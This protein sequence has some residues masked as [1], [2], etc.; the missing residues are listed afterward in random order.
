MRI[1]IADDDI[2]SRTVLASV[3]K[4][5]GHEV[6]ATVNG[7]EAWETLRQPGAPELV[8]LDWVMP[9]MD[10][11]EVVRRVRALATERPPYILMLTARGE[12]ADI[13]AGLEAG[14]NDYLSKPFDIGELRARIEV[15]RRMVEMQAA[16]VESREA[17]AHQATHDSLTGLLNRRAILDTLNREVSRASR[18]G[19]PWAVGMCD[20]DRFKQINDTYGHLTGDDILR[21][22]A[23]I[24]IETLRPHDSAGR[25]GGE[26]F[27]MIVP[28]QAQSDSVIPFN[29]LCT[30]IAESK[31]PTR[32]G[33]MS[34]TASIGVASARAG[35]KAD[36]MLEAADA[37]LYRAK[38]EGR[39]RVAHDGRCYPVGSGTNSPEN[40]GSALYGHPPLP[41]VCEPVSSELGIASLRR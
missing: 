3:L 38:G 18:T 34:I 19:G 35:S 26:E 12:K 14:A 20:I 22:F 7:A 6:Q 32:S 17:L 33:V 21:G 5:Q 30:R 16:L 31:I 27:L 13:I 39:N 4:K 41:E 23:R 2:T 9:E 10:G 36:Q 37:A 11:P 15:G 40:V 1:L 24:L 28:I 29:R 8:I 25:M